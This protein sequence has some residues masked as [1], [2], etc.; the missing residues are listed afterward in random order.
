MLLESS[1]N[2]EK[3]FKSRIVVELLESET[4]MLSIEE[5]SLVENSLL[6]V[7][8][9]RHSVKEIRILG[10]SLQFKSKVSVL[11][12]THL[13]NIVTT[14]L[15][16]K[17]KVVKRVTHHENWE[18]IFLFSGLLLNVL[19]NIVESLFVLIVG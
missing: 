12:V 10:H 15:V 14:E 8:V 17:N 19:Q 18:V 9:S 3:F 2:L 5:L 16:H 4:L 11:K 1:N 6:F 7:L 13:S